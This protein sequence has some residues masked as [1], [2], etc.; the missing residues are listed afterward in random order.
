MLGGSDFNEE[1]QRN[2]QVTIREK[3]LMMVGAAEQD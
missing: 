2:V 3:V 1:G